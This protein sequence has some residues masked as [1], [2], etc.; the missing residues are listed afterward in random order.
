MRFEVVSS[1]DP[2][3]RKDETTCDNRGES[4]TVFFPEKRVELRE[5]LVNSREKHG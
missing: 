2:R 3:A 5:M 4:T 1:G